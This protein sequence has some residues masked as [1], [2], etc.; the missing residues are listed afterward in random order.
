MGWTDKRVNVTRFYGDRRDSVTLP[1]NLDSIRYQN[2]LRRTVKFF[3][4]L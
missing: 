2:G 1:F 3:A 4:H